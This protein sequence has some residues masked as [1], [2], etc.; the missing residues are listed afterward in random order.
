VTEHHGAEH[1]VFG[2]L[3]GFRL[4]HQ[5]GVLRAG[6]DEVELADSFISSSVRV[7]HVFAI[8][9]ADAGGADRAHEG[10]AGE[11]QRRGGGDHRQN[12]RIVLQVVLETVTMTCVSF[13]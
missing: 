11:R 3:L 6:D 10:H 12:V 1:D 7:Q 9:V 5:H 4:H 8:D 13:L 2:K